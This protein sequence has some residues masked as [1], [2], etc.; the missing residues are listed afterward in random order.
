M[1]VI[2][3]T[4]R[5]HSL[6][7]FEEQVEA[8]ASGRPDMLILR[9]KD[10]DEAEYAD[11]AIVCS[12]ICRRYDV[13]ICINSFVDVARGLGIRDVQLPMGILSERHVELSGMRVGA[14]VHCVRD[15]VDAERLGAERLIFGNVFETSC[16]PGKTGTGIGMLESIC[17]AASVPVYAI[18]GITADNAAEL[19]GSGIEGICMMS[20]LMM[21]PDPAAAVDAVRRARAALPFL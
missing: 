3:V 2:A 21:S 12:D 5:V 20:S 14:S 8:I 4:D 6:R 17:D 7:P 16:K 1:M 19:S 10:L 18:G 11:L 9:E 15:V 13:A